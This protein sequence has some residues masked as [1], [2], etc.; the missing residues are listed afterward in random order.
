MVSEKDFD[1]DELKS[2]YAGL[3][4]GKS[5]AALVD[6][7]PDDETHSRYVRI[8]LSPIADSTDQLISMAN[9]CLARIR[10]ST[11]QKKYDTLMSQIGALPPDDSS[12]PALLKEAQDVQAKLRLL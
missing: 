3:I 7:A 8:L 5:P 1:D 2:I 9:Q 12:V 4:S 10:K 6:T 11:L